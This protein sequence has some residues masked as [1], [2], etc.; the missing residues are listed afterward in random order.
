MAALGAL[1]DLVFLRARQYVHAVIEGLLTLR[2][3]QRPA[4]EL[5][6]VRHFDPFFSELQ[7]LLF[8]RSLS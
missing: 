4:S 5:S 6:L 1:K 3:I 2:A 7:L 8:E